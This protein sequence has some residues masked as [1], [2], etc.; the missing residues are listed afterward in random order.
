MT[1]Q[2]NPSGFKAIRRDH[3]LLQEEVHDSYKMKGKLHEPTVCPDCGAVFH[4]GHWQWM[5]KPEKAH[6]TLCPACHRMHDHFPAGFVSI[7]GE[8]FAAHEAE[9]LQLIRH[10]EAKEKANHPLQRIMDI[11]KT[12]DGTLVTTTDIHLARGIGDALRHAYQGKLD[13]HYNPEQNL[14]RVSWMH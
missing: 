6:E 3:H 5:A 8:F 11:E 10:L 12:K 7:T 1:M 4:A 13:F 14:L 2:L 9:I